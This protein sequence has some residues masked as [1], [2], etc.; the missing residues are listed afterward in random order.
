[1]SENVRH[2]FDTN[3]LVSAVLFEHSNPGQ[4]LRRA[5]GR[6]RVLL[7]ASTLEELAE[8]L[9]REKFERY[10]TAAEREAFLI[11]FVERALFIEPTEEIRACRD[12]KDD[13]FLELAVSGKASYIISGDADLLVMHPFRRI[14]IVTATAFLQATEEESTEE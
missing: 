8:V 12:A 14:S 9:Q 5:L 11:A 6:G 2:V 4:A 13:K 1:M 10:V 7:S 3:T